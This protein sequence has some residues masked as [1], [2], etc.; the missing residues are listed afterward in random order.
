MFRGILGLSSGLVPAPELEKPLFAMRPF[1]PGFQLQYGFFDPQD[2]PAAADSHRDSDSDSGADLMTCKDDSES[3]SAP[4][5]D[6]VAGPS[7]AAPPGAVSAKVLPSI[8]W[9]KLAELENIGRGAQKPHHLDFAGSLEMAGD[10]ALTF[11]LASDG[12]LQMFEL[13]PA[14]RAW[15]TKY[16]KLTLARPFWG[17]RGASRKKHKYKR[18]LMRSRDSLCQAPREDVSGT[19]TWASGQANMGR[20]HGQV[21][22]EGGTARQAR[23]AV[24]GKGGTAPQ[25]RGRVSGEAGRAQEQPPQPACTS[26]TGG[27]GAEG[28]V[29]AEGGT[30]AQA[31]LHPPGTSVTAGQGPEKGVSGEGEV[32]GEGGKPPQPSM[33]AADVSPATDESFAVRR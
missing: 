10:I 18:K 26:G 14:R 31:R 4:R 32:S 2:L 1:P 30:A 29:S 8:S 3:G 25:A 13:Q 21:F 24:S 15:G 16:R 23:G 20:Q 6:A 9:Q 5:A 11:Q 33:Q 28:G 7:T 12:A 27:Q 22:G 17:T 19:P